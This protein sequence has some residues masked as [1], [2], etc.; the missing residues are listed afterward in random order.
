MGK[1]ALVEKLN[2]RGDFKEGVKK[3]MV[4]KPVYRQ[5]TT[6]DGI[7][8]RLEFWESVGKLL[9]SYNHAPGFEKNN[10]SLYY[11]NVKACILMFDINDESSIEEGLALAVPVREEL[12]PNNKPVPIFL[13]GNKADQIK[14]KPELIIK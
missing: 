13:V 6:P 12:L 4:T 5:L 8:V 7:I 10:S 2:V 11:R 14:E 9:Q 1:S 3:S